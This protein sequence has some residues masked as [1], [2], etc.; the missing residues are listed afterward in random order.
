MKFEKIKP[1]MT[2]YDVHSTRMGNTTARTM[3]CWLVRVVSVDTEARTAIVRWNGNSER[4]WRE[5]DLRKLRA[6]EP[7]F[8]SSVT[9]VYRIKRKTQSPPTTSATPR[10]GE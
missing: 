9:G 2:L 3:G 1:G 5:R 8:E 4:E 6:K 7:E 10:D